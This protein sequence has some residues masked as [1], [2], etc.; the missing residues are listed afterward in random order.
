[1]REVQNKLKKN[2]KT[3]E[4]QDAFLLY[5]NQKKEMKEI[6]ALFKKAPRTIYRWIKEVKMARE[7]GL[8]P[9]MS[10]RKRRRKYPLPVFER[11]IALK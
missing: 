8:D 5:Y 2:E 10:K 6:A 9:R 11:I 1:M 3:L 4:K 7:D